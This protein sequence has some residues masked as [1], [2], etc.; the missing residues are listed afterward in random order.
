MLD[1]GVIQDGRE[2][3][4]NYSEWCVFKTYELYISGISYFRTKI[5]GN[6][7]WLRSTGYVNF[8]L[9]YFYY[10]SFKTLFDRL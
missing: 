6:K 7:P 10:V 3:S 4:S 5:T 8:R 1:K 2:I 9:I